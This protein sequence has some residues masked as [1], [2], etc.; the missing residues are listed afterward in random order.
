[1]QALYPYALVIHLS[2][3][4]IFLG[5]LFFDVVIL[6]RAL[7]LFTPELANK[8]EQAIGSRAI[9]IMPICVLLLLL[10]GGIM[11]SNY[12]G[13]ERG[14]LQTPFQQVLLFK[15]AL[16]CVIFAL[17]IFS[18]GCKLFHKANPL[19]P[20]IHPLVLALGVGIILCAKWMW[21]I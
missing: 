19:A 4:V 20:I 3:A 10:T 8:I 15:V 21:F 11:L 5:Y 6:A 12:V 7:K 13:G 9:K 2:C 1:M 18:L 14:W 16:A 17:V